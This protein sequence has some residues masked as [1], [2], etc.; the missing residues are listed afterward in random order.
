MKSTVLCA[1]SVRYPLKRLF[2]AIYAC[3]NGIVAAKRKLTHVF[4]V[5]NFLDIL[6]VCNV[7]YALLLKH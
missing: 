2:F 6:E 7:L 1:Y 5:S 4:Q 3:I